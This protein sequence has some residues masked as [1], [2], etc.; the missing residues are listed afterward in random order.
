L[1]GPYHQNGTGRNQFD[2]VEAERDSSHRSASWLSCPGRAGHNPSAAAASPTKMPISLVAVLLS[3]VLLDGAV[4]IA[5]EESPDEAARSG[6]RQVSAPVPIQ[7]ERGGSV[8]C[9]P[10]TYRF[11]TTRTC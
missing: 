10:P 7:A 11:V 8:A 4:P 2:M 5:A 6:S 1:A 3:L 9:L